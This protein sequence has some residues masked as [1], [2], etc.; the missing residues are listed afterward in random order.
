MIESFAEFERRIGHRTQIY[1]SV[2]ARVSNA[3]NAGDCDP[4]RDTR[5]R[6]GNADRYSL[7][8]RPQNVSTADPCPTNPEADQ[9]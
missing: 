4:D 7:D 8:H 2:L 1:A 3:E 6:S 5:E 9:Q